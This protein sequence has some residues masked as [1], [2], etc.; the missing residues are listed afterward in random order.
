MTSFSRFYFCCTM[1]LYKKSTTVWSKVS[2]EPCF[3]RT[4]VKMLWLPSCVLHY[5]HLKKTL[6]FLLFTSFKT[7]PPYFS[8]CASSVIILIKSFETLSIFNFSCVC[9]HLFCK[10][11]ENI[12][13]QLRCKLLSF[14][15]WNPFTLTKVAQTSFNTWKRGSY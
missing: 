12:L 9:F 11:L 2:V 1:L 4:S 6:G 10:T 8:Q 5:C 7:Y 14:R 15:H 13:I 3:F